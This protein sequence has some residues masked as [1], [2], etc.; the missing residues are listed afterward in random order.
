[1]LGDWE[2]KIIW[3]ADDLTQISPPSL[4]TLDP[5]DENIVIG[6]PEDVVKDADKDGAGGSASESRVTGSGRRAREKPDRTRTQALI[7]KTLEK[8]REEAEAAAADAEKQQQHQKDNAKTGGKNPWNLSNDEY[9]NPKQS[10]SSAL[11]GAMGHGTCL[12][13]STPAVEL[14]QPYFP[15]KMSCPQLRNFHRP[16]LKKYSHGPMSFFKCHPVQSLHK[17]I[18]KKAKLREQERLASGGGEMFFMRK[19]AD[20]TGKDATIILAE[21]C[22][23]FP[24]LLNQVSSS[25][26]L[27]MFFIL[28]FSSSFSLLAFFSWLFSPGYF[29]LA[30]FSWLFFSWLFSPGFFPPVFFSSYLFFLLSFYLLSFFLLVLFFSLFFSFLTSFHC[31]LLTVSSFLSFLL[32]ASILFFLLSIFPTCS[33]SLALSLSIRMNAPYDFFSSFS[34][35]GMATKIKNFY[36]RKPGKD[37]GAPTLPFGETAFAHTSPF[38]GTLVPGQC[39]QALENNLFR[40]P[41]YHHRLAPTDFLIIRSRQQLW[42]REIKD[43]FTVGQSCPLYEVPGPNSKRT[44]IFTR[45]FLQVFIYR[46]FWKSKE[47]R[48]RSMCRLMLI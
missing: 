30:F 46:Q 15:T 26:F 13:H 21:Y 44:N 34:Q 3:D 33:L 35:V 6:M 2:S 47:G 29:L 23:E 10:T 48:W 18:R 19:P 9:Y 11:Y 27:P 22:E 37:A 24:P 5:N 28:S 16:P 31:F 12:Q 20:L 32:S 7:G 39:V 45:D 14:R 43:V 42:V 4:L 40:A 25:F 38:L 36:K 41:I 17:T 8:T 1:M